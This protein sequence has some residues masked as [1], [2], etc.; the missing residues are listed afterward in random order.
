MAHWIWPSIA[1][2]GLGLMVLGLIRFI[3]GGFPAGRAGRADDDGGPS[4]PMP[5]QHRRAWWGLGIAAS[6]SAALAVNVT[7]A[8][9]ADYWQNRE[10]RLL[11]WAVLL[12]GGL[13]YAAVLQVTRAR[14]SRSVTAIDERDRAIMIRA[15]SVA[16][17]TGLLTLV[18]WS[19]GLTEAFRE[20]QAIPIAYPSYIMWSTLLVTLLGREAGVLLG[21]AGWHAHGEG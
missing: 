17:V 4:L 18:A 5:L 14:S 19:I 3:R 8:G 20:E 13:A 1:I 12:V 10:A 6:V 9:P 15:L 11:G 7:I 2:V 16:L 21:Y